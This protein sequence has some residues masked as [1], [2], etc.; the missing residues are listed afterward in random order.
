[1]NAPRA[2][3][4]AAKDAEGDI[5]PKADGE[6]GS[7]PNPGLATRSLY[8]PSRESLERGRPGSLFRKL[9][10]NPQ[11]VR[12]Y[13]QVV[14]ASGRVL[15]RSIPNVTLPVDRARSRS[16]ATGANPSSAMRAS[17][18]P[19]CACWRPASGPTERSSWR[20][21]WAKSTACSAVCG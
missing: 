6:G 4:L 14:E 19:T 21:R 3:A 10:P 18:A 1:M 17:T 11:Q 15:A 2:F 13:Q 9:P 12:G 16:P 20:C 8:G 7:G 5:N